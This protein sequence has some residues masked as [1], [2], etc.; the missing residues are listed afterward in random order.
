MAFPQEW[1]D[2]L[3]AR[4]PLCVVI[5]DFV[6]L[7]SIRKGDEWIGFCPFHA[8]KTPSFTV[9]ECKG[10]WHC[11][12]CGQ[13][14]TAIDFLAYWSQS[15]GTAVIPNS[16][17]FENPRGPHSLRLFKYEICFVDPLE[18]SHRVTHDSIVYH[19]DY[20]AFLLSYGYGKAV[21]T[22]ADLIGLE[23]PNTWLPRRRY[24]W[25]KIRQRG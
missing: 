13:N 4:I 9:S 19:G 3:K 5:G 6:E 8:E 12:G 17:L 16:D 22:L 15:L 20:E 24:A 14:G 7:R 23:A 21:L 18:K 2:E 1:M 10:F 11:F 25:K